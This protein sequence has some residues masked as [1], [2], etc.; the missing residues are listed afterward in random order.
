M[1][2]RLAPAAGV[3][4]GRLKTADFPNNRCAVT[5]TLS[6]LTARTAFLSLVVDT[7]TGETTLTD[8]K[9]NHTWEGIA[10]DL[11]AVPDL[12]V[13]AIDEV[14]IQTAAN[15][16][17]DLLNA[18]PLC[19]QVRIRRTLLGVPWVTMLT[20]WNDVPRVD[21]DLHTQWP[22]LE[23]WQLRMP[24]AS[25][26][27][28]SS[29]V[30]GTAFHGSRWDEIPEGARAGYSPDEI[31]FEDW[32]RYREVQQWLH[33]KAANAGMTIATRHPA[34]YHDGST[35]SAVLFRTP[36]NGGDRRFHFTNE[37]A[38]NWHFEIN[39]GEADWAR[40][41]ERGDVSW[42]R[43]IIHSG[44]VSGDLNLLSSDTEF[45]Q[46]SA[47]IPVAD[48][49][50]LARL[51]NQSDQVQTAELTGSLVGSAAEEFDLDDN[52]IAEITSTERGLRT[53]LQ[54]WQI[55][56]LRLHPGTT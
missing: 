12:G 3:G 2:L 10:A 8:L 7:T 6:D 27:P 46:L 29:V 54:P 37:G 32:S 49:C 38:N 40:A 42:R 11:T 21:V 43:P 23:N 1:A 44:H 36:P 34:F 47:L 13:R 53:T 56:T 41:P 5:R 14:N 39:L 33:V 24:V 30:Y 55:K 17:V 25:G 22:G 35:L 48:G 52:V 31:R 50:V 51:V 19:Q 9:R 26:V 45:V 20:L 18:G 15:A 28:Q 4:Y 16:E